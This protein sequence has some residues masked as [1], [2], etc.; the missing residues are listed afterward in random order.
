MNDKIE[1]EKYYLTVPVPVDY[2]KVQG[3]QKKEKCIRPTYSYY[4][5]YYFGMDANYLRNAGDTSIYEGTYQN[6]TTLSGQQV[7]NPLQ[8]IGGSY[9]VF[10]TQVEANRGYNIGNAE[11]ELEKYNK[12][13]TNKQE[14]R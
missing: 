8:S 1:E 5:N 3:D 9:K 7:V 13:K 14:L 4:H 6:L 2:L 11:D 12:Y 10:S